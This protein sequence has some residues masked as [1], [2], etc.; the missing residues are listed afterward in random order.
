MVQ[1]LWL[2]LSCRTSTWENSDTNFSSLIQKAS[3]FVFFILSNV[4]FSMITVELPFMTFCERMK[5]ELDSFLSSRLYPNELCIL[6]SA[7]IMKFFLSFS[8]INFKSLEFFSGS[9]FTLKV[10]KL[11]P[12]SAWNRSAIEAKLRFSSPPNMRERA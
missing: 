1:K 12:V 4:Y 8:E 6:F 5:N 9:S 3:E 2:I 10:R 7:L 11:D